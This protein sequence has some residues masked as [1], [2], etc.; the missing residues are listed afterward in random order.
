M[1]KSSSLSFTLVIASIIIA[2]VVAYSV[3]A[4]ALYNIQSLHTST[5]ENYEMAMYDGYRTEIKSQVQ[6]VLAILQNLYEKELQGLLTSEEARLQGKET[7][8]TMRYRDD[9][10]GYFWIDDKNYC[11]VMHPILT[12]DEGKNRYDLQDQ[13]GVM[14]VQSILGECLSPERAGF[15]S[16]Y[17]TK[18]DGV[19][20]APKLAY[21]AYFEP[22]GW[23]IST[24]NY[25]DDMDKQILVAEKS[26]QNRIKSLII[27]MV[28]GTTILLVLSAIII[29]IVILKIA[30]KP[31]R[32]LDTNIFDL[33]EG[34]ADLTRRLNFHSFKEMNS[35][36]NG[37]NKF[38]DKIHN[39][40]RDIKTSKLHLEAVGQQLG[41]SSYETVHSINQI[42]SHI[43]KLRDEMKKQS[44]SVTETASSV[45]EITSNIQSLE[46]MI[47]SQA[48]EVTQASASVE[49]MLAN[50]A[51]VTNSM[52]KMMVLF[53][54][55]SSEMQIGNE[56]QADVNQ[57]IIEIEQQSK[58]LHEANVVIAS[59][60]EQTNMLAMNAAIEAAHAGDAG[61]GFSV[62]ADEIRKLSETSSEQSR[63][64]GTQLTKIHTAIENMVS[65]SEESSQIFSSVSQQIQDTNTLVVQIQS[66]MTEQSSGSQQIATA[67]HA[68]NNSTI[69]VKKASTEMTTGNKLIFD[70]VQKLQVAVEQM[71]SSMN[72]M[73]D[74][75]RKI[76]ERGQILSEISER[77]EETIKD[78]SVRIEQFI[79]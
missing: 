73:N 4:F 72:S 70:E 5:N 25:V 41:N 50:I 40:V 37:F 7:V 2:F 64:I 42:S 15:N 27:A 17:F 30:V 19:T 63:N 34:S 47:Q 51:A 71:D 32:V 78:I 3:G 16:F 53:D 74:E 35:I 24:G 26:S 58:M 18:A 6:S 39:T 8:R 22:W 54:N 59:I 43:Q 79:V 66:A 61:R 62:V 21:S 10:S 20:V 23:A 45:N 38:T 44:G 68:M 28:V 76:F 31:L 56:R 52:D 1:K 48:A 65:V 67:L 9:G 69:E 11:L 33:A 49:E 60:A 75:A 77:M 14:I 36:T 29:S 57:R 12:A 13:N 55:L 46:R